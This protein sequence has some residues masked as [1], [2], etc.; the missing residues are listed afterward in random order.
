L[1]HVVYSRV[2][3]KYKKV[4]NYIQYS[5]LL[6]IKSAITNGVFMKIINLDVAE[7]T[8]LDTRDDLFTELVVTGSV[9]I[10]NHRVT[11]YEMLEDMDDENKDCILAMLLVDSAE[12]K[13]EY[14]EVLWAM[15]LS[16][17]DDE[18]IEKHVIDEGE[19]L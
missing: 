8:I 9:Y 1:N 16:E 18:A 19:S 14:I 5:P 7:S 2:E 6:V 10:N 13:A 17:F 15:F 4:C 12:A 3:I 11:V